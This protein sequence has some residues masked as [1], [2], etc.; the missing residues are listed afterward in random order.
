LSTLTLDESIGTDA[1]DSNAASDDVSG[2]SAP[3]LMTVLDTSKAIGHVSTPTS[4][5]GTSVAELFSTTV[6]F[7]ADGAKAAATSNYSLTLTDDHGHTVS[8]GSSSGVETN[9]VVTALAGTPL[10]GTSDDQRTIYLFK[11]ADGSIIGKIGI[12]GGGNVADDIALRIVIT[13]SA[14]DPQIT[15]EQYLPIQHS[16]HSSSD[17]P[18]SLTFNDYDASLGI[19]LTVSATDGDGDVATDSKTVTLASHDSSLIKIEDDGPTVSIVA[20]SATVIHDETPG[21]QTAADPN[22]ANDVAGSALPTGVLALFNAISNPGSDPDVSVKDNG[23]IGFA[24]SAASL[25]NVTADFGTDGHAINNSQVLSLTIAG[26]NGVNSGLKTTDGHEIDLFLENGLIVGRYDGSDLNST[27]TN[28]SA[29]NTT[30]DPAAFAIAI[31]QDGTISI[32]QYVS[33]LNPTPGTSYDEPAVG[34]QNVLATVT[35]TDGDGDT[36]VNSVDISGHVQFQ[37]DGPTLTVTAPAALNGLDFGTFTPNGNAWGIGSGTA[38]GTNGGWTI[39]NSDDGQGDSGVVQLE[40]VG[41]GYL[42]MHSS[43][44]GF[45]VDLDASPHD[46]KIS[47]TTGLTNGQTTFL[48]FEAGA[49][50]PNL[51]HLEVWF[52]GAKIADIAPTG[53]MQ[54]YTVGLVGGFGDTAT[55]WNSARPEPPTIR[56]RIS[57]M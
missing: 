29:P 35:V 1:N 34:L 41:D 6:H 15:V 12:G 18:A 26:G 57:P 45:M 11:Q 36:K 33:L 52:G 10:A 20:T 43:T 2:V 56:A 14:T 3:T 47:Q 9:L 30:T 7:G 42:G 22:A 32:A 8:N 28:G 25:V 53:T 19:T 27:I 31:S 24:K 37:D 5:N 40:R 54:S 4:A 38:T 50:F 21:L 44:N 13:G 23:A 16:N 48:T 55:C 46:V 49:P 17:E 51:A 39:A